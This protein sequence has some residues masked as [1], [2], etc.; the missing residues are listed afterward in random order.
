MIGAALVAAFAASALVPVQAGTRAGAPP[1]ALAA[2]PL[3]VVLAGTGWSTVRVTNPSRAGITVDTATS[4]FALDLGGRPRVAPVTAGAAPAW[5]TV[6][7]RRLRLRAAASALV[8]VSARIPHGA[9]PGEHD[10][11]L[12]LRTRARAPGSVPIVMQVGVVIVVRVHG[13]TI[14]RLEIRALRVRRVAGRRTLLLTL[15]NRGNVSEVL[16]VRRLRVLL[17][18]GRRV[19]ATLL[20][21]RRHLLPHS[22]GVI[23]MRYAGGARGIVV[24]V[25]ELR[26]PRAGVAVLRRSFRIRV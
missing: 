2:S 21:P 23:S 10:A 11:L 16:P 24:A 13:P 25:V 8:T 20:P 7:P 6:A 14:H 22:S 3:R 26:R 4:G 15:R 9:S 19:L 5:L 17:R 18:S 12:L 1:L